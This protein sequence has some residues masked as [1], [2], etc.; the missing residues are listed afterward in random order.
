MTRWLVPP[1]VL[2]ALFVLIMSA[3]GLSYWL[4]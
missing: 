2:P 3:Y 1:I 4:A